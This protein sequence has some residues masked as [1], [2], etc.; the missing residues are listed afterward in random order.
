M[1]GDSIDL[2]DGKPTGSVRVSFGYM[3][4][5]DNCQN[6]LSF[7]VDCFVEKPAR[8][9]QARLENLR[10]TQAA[11]H[12][13][14]SS[15]K[16][17]FPLNGSVE[18]GVDEMCGPANEIPEPSTDIRGGQDSIGDTSQPETPYTLTNIY[19]I[20]RAHV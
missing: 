6:F 4:T 13:G 16:L 1:C 11:V 19:K 17:E 14:D 10:Q 7:I 15:E 3:S 20:G 12:S 8:V 2:V 18:R 5:F 9:D